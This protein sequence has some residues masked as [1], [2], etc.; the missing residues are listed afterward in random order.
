[1][2]RV[3]TGNKPLNTYTIYQL[4]SNSNTYNITYINRKQTVMHVLVK[5]PATKTVNDIQVYQPE[6]N[7]NRYT[8]YQ[9]ETNSNACT[10]IATGNKQ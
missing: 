4:E 1:M 2:Y 8:V 10:G 9:A 7:R 3:S 6:T 5:Q